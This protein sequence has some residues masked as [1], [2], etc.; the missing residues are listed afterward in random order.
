MVTHPVARHQ[1]AE[2]ASNHSRNETRRYR[3]RAGRPHEG[4]EF[5]RAQ[6]N[7]TLVS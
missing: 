5:A 3:R 7:V 4:E 2:N 1:R 6:R